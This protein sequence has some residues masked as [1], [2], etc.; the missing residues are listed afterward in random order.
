MKKKHWWFDT[1]P[2]LVQAMPLLIE[3]SGMQIAVENTIG[4]FPI[5]SEYYKKFGIFDRLQIMPEDG[6]KAN[7]MAT[8]C[9]CLTWHPLLSQFGSRLVLSE[10]FG[11]KRNN[12]MREYKPIEKRKYIVYGP[13]LGAKNGRPVSNEPKL[14]EELGKWVEE[15]TVYKFV[16]FNKF[17]APHLSLEQY[18]DL[19]SDAAVIAG[20]HGG[21]FANMFFS[22]KSDSNFFSLFPHF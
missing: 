7:N 6:I 20:S 9:T 5:V 12:A 4:E 2:K 10:G 18:L 11:E 21:F 16:D 22:F 3:D 1:L 17:H 8:S 19:F 15:C 13:R 14:I